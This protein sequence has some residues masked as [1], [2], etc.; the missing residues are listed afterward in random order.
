V[1]QK[2]PGEVGKASLGNSLK[3]RGTF[4]ITCEEMVKIVKI[5]EETIVRIF[6]LWYNTISVN[7]LT[8]IVRRSHLQWQKLI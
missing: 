8:K 1:H 7:S 3:R 6:Y 2:S 4:E 5:Q